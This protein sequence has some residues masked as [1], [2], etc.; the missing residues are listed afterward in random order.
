MNRSMDQEVKSEIG[1]VIKKAREDQ[2][3]TKEKLADKSDV[4]VTSI[5]K[6]EKGELNPRLTTVMRIIRV[7]GIELK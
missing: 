6:I 1:L 3:L 5:R 4:A 7:L 2:R